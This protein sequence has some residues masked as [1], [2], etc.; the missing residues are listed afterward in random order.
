MLFHMI[1]T[2]VF[3][4]G[5]F[6]QVME[7]IIV[8]IY[9]IM[10]ILIFVP[11]ILYINEL[12]VES[13]IN[14]PNGYKLHSAY[15]NPF[16]PYTTLGYYLPNNETVHI[17]IFDIMGRQVKTFV[18]PDQIAGYGSIQ[19]NGTNDYDQRVSSGLYLYTIQAGNFRGTKK[20][21]ILE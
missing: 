16:N 6:S 7:L 15:P 12:N 17:K 19:W 14:N 11:K 13:I 18:M 4:E 1:I 21:V 5:H 8:I 2:G 10:E 3:L 9:Q 20:M